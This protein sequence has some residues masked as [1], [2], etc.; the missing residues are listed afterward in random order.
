MSEIALER[1]RIPVG[2]IILLILMALGLVVGIV[3]FTEGL[4]ATT[5]L[6]DF[7]P[8]GLWLGFDVI[9]GVALGAGAFT[10]AA[11]V[12]IFNLKKYRPILRPAI[13]TGFLGYLLVI[14][15][16]LAD[17]GQPWRLWHAII[18]WNPHSVLFEVAWCVMLYTT[19]MFLELLPLV[20]ERFNKPKLLRAAHAVTLPLVI[21]GI[22]LS[23]LHQSSLG[24]L[25]MIMPDK[26]H[27][28]YLSPVLPIFFYVSAIAVG[29]AMVIVESSLSAKAFKRG[30]EMDILSNLGRAIPYVLGFYLVFRLGDLLIA[31][32]LWLMFRGT[33]MSNLFLVEI[34]GGVVLPIVLFSIR[35]VRESPAGLFWSAVIV[36]VGLVLNRIVMTLVAPQAS[37]ETTYFPTWMEFALT[38][39]LVSTG[40]FAFMLAS[41]FLP[42]FPEEAGSH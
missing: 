24:S 36:I 8:W 14:M 2:T 21:A 25:F 23:T 20:F 35:K 16:L 31:G 9:S 17:L 28:L 4:G 18:Y 5:D 12:Y 38:V 3:R 41:R 34:V 39:G 7:Y 37:V 10:I 15:G 32:E 6:S 22:T 42:V 40:V 26:L 13:L 1:R 11:V 19:V 27:P 33:I 30:L 29:L